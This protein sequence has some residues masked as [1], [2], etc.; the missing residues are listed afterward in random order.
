MSSQTVL[1]KKKKGGLFGFLGGN[2]GTRGSLLNSSSKLLSAFDSVQANVLIADTSFTLIYANPKAVETLG[3]IEDEIQIAFKVSLGDIVGSSIHRF[4]KAPHQ[5]VAILQ[6]PKALPHETQFTFGA[7][8]LSA[9][10]NGI[11]DSQRGI[12]GYVVNWENVTEKQITE[13]MTTQQKL[14][15]E[16]REKEIT[17]NMQSV[18]QDVS[19]TAD[20]LAASSSQLNSLSQ[21][22]SARAE[23]T[24]SQASMI[25]AA[26]EQVSTN[27]NTVATGTEAMSASIR[28]IASNSSEAAK[29]TSEAVTLAKNTNATVTQLDESL[30]EIGGQVI[31]VITSI[32]AQAYLLALN[33]TIEVARAGEAGKGFAVVADEVKELSNQ[34]AK[35]AEDISQKTQ[36]IQTDTS[37]AVTAI[38]EISDVINRVNDISNTIASAAEEQTATTNEMTWNV[39]EAAKGAQEITENISGVAQAAQETLQGTPQALEAAYELQKLAAALQEVVA[40]GNTQ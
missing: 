34:T 23:E 9:N 7:V 35:A 8:T 15:A 10:I 38:G 14:A 18:L 3:A 20:T 6:N 16:A 4:H 40:R 30:A 13:K 29:I 22:M 28:A 37:S 2:G 24:S 11:F 31:K 27:V 26:S 21:T 1:A 32:A 39:T 12:L 36:A 19:K 25:S 33:A 17:E 5:I